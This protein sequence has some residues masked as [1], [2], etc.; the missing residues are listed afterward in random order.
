MARG[1]A[2]NAQGDGGDNCFVKICPLY[3][4]KSLTVYNGG[5]DQETT[6]TLGYSAAQ[7]KPCWR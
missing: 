1:S 4:Q 3:E 5:G 7:V 2:C 6:E